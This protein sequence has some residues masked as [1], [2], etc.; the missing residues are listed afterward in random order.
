MPEWLLLPGS[1][2]QQIVFCHIALT[3]QILIIGEG[4][5]QNWAPPSYVRNDVNYFFV[6]KS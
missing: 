5:D 2:F 3:I 6:K 4:L 1:E